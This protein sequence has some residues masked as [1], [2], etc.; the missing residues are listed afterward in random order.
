MLSPSSRPTTPGG[1]AGTP[2][3]GRGA[4]TPVGSRASGG[5]AGIHAMRASGSTTKPVMPARRPLCGPSAFDMLR[6]REVAQAPPVDSGDVEA[7]E[8]QPVEGNEG[9]FTMPPMS[10]T[11]SPNG[12]CRER[13]AELE[14]EQPSSQSVVVPQ[15]GTHETG[16]ESAADYV[17]RVKRSMGIANSAAAPQSAA[18]HEDIV[19]SVPRQAAVS[20]V[21][22]EPVPAPQVRSSGRDATVPVSQGRSRSSDPRAAVAA[23]RAADAAANTRSQ[24]SDPRPS[25]VS[26]RHPI[27][28]VDDDDDSDDEDDNVRPLP[29]DGG[30]DVKAGGA[31]WKLDVKAM[32][33]DFAREERT[34]SGAAPPARSSA[35]PTAKAAAPP[36]PPKV[37]PSLAQRPST[38]PDAEKSSVPAQENV[39]PGGELFFSKKPR[40]VDYVPASLDDFKQKGYAKKEI[41]QLGKLG[42][43]LD[44]DQLLMKR[45]IQEKKKQFSKELQRVN[46]QRMSVAA[47]SKDAKPEPKPEPKATARAKAQE[48]A[49][50]LPKPK[51]PQAAKPATLERKPKEADNRVDHSSKEAARDQ[52]DWDE[53]RRREKQHFDD[54]LRVKDIKDF[55]S[56]LP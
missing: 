18:A 40:D 2:T 5:Y 28:P 14:A 31:P 11:S 7:A 56:Q 23:V 6:E 8:A 12:D 52:A 30:S 37:P 36:R 17:E 53:I 45:A 22:E 54:V 41:A 9:G 47:A 15:R 43:D 55:L 44:D 50:N 1:V 3:S 32:V 46:R 33:K 34:R 24:S 13:L 49:R 35:G 42:P 19:A 25:A 38:E 29:S 16:G 20:A 26:I 4:A 51:P 39:P 27:A 21:Q 10:D 48:F